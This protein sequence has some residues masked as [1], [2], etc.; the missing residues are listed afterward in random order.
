MIEPDP[1]R[2]RFSAEITQFGRWLGRVMKK[3]FWLMG[4]LPPL[5]GFAVYL[6][7]HRQPP[8]LS[9]LL[10]WGLAPAASLSLLSIGLLVSAYLV[11]RETA[12]QLDQAHQKLAI[13]SSGQLKAHLV[14]QTVTVD[15]WVSYNDLANAVQHLPNAHLD[16]RAT[17][18]LQNTRPI[19]TS[20][21]LSLHAAACH[22]EKHAT[23]PSAT[24]PLVAVVSTALRLPAPFPA[25]FALDRMKRRACRS[26]SPSP[27]APS[28]S[29][30]RAPS[31]PFN[32]SPRPGS[33]R[34]QTLSRSTSSSPMMWLPSTDRHSSG[35][36]S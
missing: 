26:D 19:P 29:L 16:L 12:S 15:N 10:Q 13:Q 25:F 35:L 4:L 23:Y 17:V 1:S 8:P 18:D 36:P 21:Q 22:L 2:S 9:H 3:L 24:S 30:A 32:T 34:S 5:L 31:P 33:S 11:H 27:S 28:P 6:A 20:F 7:T 14:Q